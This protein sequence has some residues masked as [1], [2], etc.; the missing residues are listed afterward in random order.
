MDP[1]PGTGPA[2]ISSARMR[3]GVVKRLAAA[4]S[5]MNTAAL[6]A[7][8]SPILLHLAGV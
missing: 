5:E 3:A 2:L 8:A 4:S 6:A 7:L 1:R